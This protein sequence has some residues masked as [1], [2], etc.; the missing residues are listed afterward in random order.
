MNN[1]IIVNEGFLL[2]TL[3]S[4]SKCYIADVLEKLPS[5]ENHTKEIGKLVAYYLDSPTIEDATPYWSIKYINYNDNIPV[6]KILL[7]SILDSLIANNKVKQPIWI[8]ELRIQK[9]FDLVSIQRGKI[10]TDNM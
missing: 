5:G 2:R 9:A 10:F 1:D 4:E 8:K 3:V 7:E 6:S